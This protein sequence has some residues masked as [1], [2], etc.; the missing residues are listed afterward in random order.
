M[1]DVDLLRVG[2]AFDGDELLLIERLILFSGVTSVVR[3]IR[4]H[5]F[6]AAVVGDLPLSDR[7]F[8]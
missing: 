6:V 4:V 8:V 1:T 7:L 2:L 5:H 3:H